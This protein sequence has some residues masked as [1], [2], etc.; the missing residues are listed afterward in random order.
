MIDNTLQTGGK[1][2]YTGSVI[3]LPEPPAGVNVIRDVEFGSHERQRYDVYLPQA[4]SAPMPVVVFFHPGGWMRRDKRAVR[5][6]FVLEHGYALVSIGYRL[7]QDACFPAQVQDVNAGM[8]HLIENASTYGVD[9]SRIVLA[10]TSAGAHLAAL[11][12]LARD[13]ADFNTVPNLELKGVV[14]IYGAYDF[15]QFLTAVQNSETDQSSAES[16]LGLL[17]G[18]DPLRHPDKLVTISPVT[19][20]R[21]DAPPFLIMHGEQDK[22]LP[23]AQS[24]SLAGELVKQGASVDFEII[25]NAGHGD[26]VFRQPPISDRIVRFIDR[27][28][29]L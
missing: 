24:A 1:P 15:P 6:M 18:G 7:A 8:K 11:A 2:Q 26:E 12:A 20:A 23:W 27:V 16:P 13:Q 3:P 10:G 22:V 9:T 21:R 5:T 28:M 4:L 29:A 25:P 19:Y 14:A 17:I